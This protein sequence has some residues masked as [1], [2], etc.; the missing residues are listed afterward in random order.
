MTDKTADRVIEIYGK[1]KKIRQEI[2][3]LTETL[4]REY[5]VNIVRCRAN[6][7]NEYINIQLSEKDIK[8]LIDVRIDQ[9]N[10]L[11]DELSKL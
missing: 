1:I 10:V 7:R 6:C 2:D 3:R 9:W 5:Q 4:L 11:K 8:A